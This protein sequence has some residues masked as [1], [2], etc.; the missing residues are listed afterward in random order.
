MNPDR[1][2]LSEKLVAKMGKG[3]RGTVSGLEKKNSIFLKVHPGPE[4]LMGSDFDDSEDGV[5]PIGSESGTELM[6]FMSGDLSDASEAPWEGFDQ[7]NRALESLTAVDKIENMIAEGLIGKIFN[8]KCES[9]EDID[10]IIKKFK[11]L[12]EGN[13]RNRKTLVDGGY[14]SESSDG[15][16]KVTSGEAG[17]QQTKIMEAL[18]RML[19]KKQHKL[20]A[21]DVQGGQLAN[22]DSPALAE[23]AGITKSI[24]RMQ[25]SDLTLL[26]AVKKADTNKAIH[27]PVTHSTASISI[28]TITGSIDPLPPS[29]PPHPPLRKS[30]FVI[31]EELSKITPANFP[32]YKLRLTARL[33]QD[34]AE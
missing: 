15:A 31:N 11:M 26:E 28:L 23:L 2:L 29:P 3:R 33:L 10:G 1:A 21:I 34:V 13:P 20:T 30:V 9:M 4:N 5:D 7:I 27:P 16:D 18:T 6:K 14:F 32:A 12:G 22:P 25:I 8:N 19:Q 24:R 17:D